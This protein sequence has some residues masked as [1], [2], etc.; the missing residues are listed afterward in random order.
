MTPARAPAPVVRARRWSWRRAAATRRSPRRCSARPASPPS[1]AATCRRCWPRC[2]TTAPASRWWPRRRCTTADLAPL[3]ALARG[4]A[5]LVG[6][7][8]RAAD[9]PRR[10]AGAQSRRAALARARWATSASSSGRSIRPRW[11]AWC[12]PR[13]AAASGSTRRAPGSRRSATARRRCSAPT[14]CWRSASPSDRPAQAN[15][16][17]T[18]QMAERERVEEQLRQA[19][20]L[21]A[22][23][24]LTGGVAHDFNNL[25]MAV[26]GNLDAAAQAPAGRRPAHPAADRRRDAGRPARRGADPAA[27]GLRPAPGRCEPEPVDL[28]D[29]GRG[30]G[31]PAAPLARRHA[32]RSRPVWRR[33]TCRR[34][35]PTP[36]S[37]SSPCSTWRSTPATPCRRAAQLVDPL[38]ASGAGGGRRPARA[39]ACYLRLRVADTGTGHGRGDAGPRGRALLHHQGGRQGHRAS[40]CRWCMAWPGSSAATCGSAAA[41][42]R[43]PPPS[44]CCLP[45]PPAA[46]AAAARAEAAAA[47]RPTAARALAHPGGRRRPADHPQHRRH[48]GGSGP[49]ACWRR[50]RREGPGDPGRRRAGGPA[51]DRLRHARHDRARGRRAAQRLRPGL[52]VVLAS[53]FVDLASGAAPAPT[54]R[55]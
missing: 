40:G 10:R 43:A 30:H 25:L 51:G 48:A 1:R 9:P 54:C 24:Q 39:A 12:A 55:A 8:V 4:A 45:P 18:E 19:Q 33:R 53:G 47:P 15:D 28:D 11:S 17:L 37:S 34:R 35:W 52:Q 26:L 7:A 29:A 36:T 31:R 14:R 5:G 41:G 21:E 16:Q 6:L 13:C 3:A 27:A 32:S 46:G 22:V 23:G 2:W 20:K 44:C 38:D 50:M 42:R 49:H